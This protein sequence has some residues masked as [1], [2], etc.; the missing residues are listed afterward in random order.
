MEGRDRT[1]Y[2]QYHRTHG[3]CT[4]QCKA[5]KQY[6]EN[7][8]QQGDFQK[9]IK[10]TKPLTS[11]LEDRT[12]KDPKELPE[13][14]E[15]SPSI[16]HVIDAHPTSTSTIW[17]EQRQNQRALAYWQQAP[18]GML[19]CTN[20]SSYLPWN[21]ATINFTPQDLQ[22]VF[23][24]HNDPLVVTLQI[25]VTKFREYWSTLK[26]QLTYYFTNFTDK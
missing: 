10:S 26:T 20:I 9:Y 16:I 11:S 21:P 6:R 1:K 12:L 23:L 7:L 13:L 4:N 17:R 2:C 19:Q 15:K 25:G 3:H 24:P 5:L 14:E 22:H 18:R 8:V